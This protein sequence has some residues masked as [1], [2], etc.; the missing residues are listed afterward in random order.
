MTTPRPHHAM[1]GNPLEQL[2]LEQLRGRTSWKW[3]TYDPDVVPLWVAEMDV[4]LAPAIA[5]RLHRSVEEGDTGYPVGSALGAAFADFAARRWGWDNVEV[6]RTA[7]VP[8]VMHGLFAMIEALTAPGDAVIVNPPVYTPF[9][10]YT[11]HHRRRIIE[12]PLGADLRLDL[13]TLEHAFRDATKDRNTAVFLLCNPHNPTGVVHTREELTAVATLADRHG[14]R[15]VCDEIHAPLTL[16]GARFTP[17]LSVPGGEQAIAATSA[18]KAWNLAGLKAG[19]LVAGPAA[20]ADLARVA[21]WLARGAS[22]LGILAHTVAYTD[23]E[24]WLDDLIAGLDE[25]RAL[26]GDLLAQHLPQISWSPPEATFLAWL[27]GSR[28]PN[29]SAFPTSGTGF[30][31]LTGVARFF[32]DQARV[33]LSPGETFG[34]GGNQHVRLN[35]ATSQQVLTDAV[36]AMGDAVRRASARTHP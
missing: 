7:V 13:E 19:L 23:G 26:L 14:V 36:A 12:A 6:A 5:A 32:H 20:A 22:H 33:A 34:T 30:S 9:Y 28:L 29:V 15:V 35:F 18:S 3:R 24:E 2:T 27:N 8:D 11:E 31:D 1:R 21:G 4:P 16:P 25:N 17:M 10:L